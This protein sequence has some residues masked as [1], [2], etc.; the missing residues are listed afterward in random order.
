MELFIRDN[1]VISDSSLRT[2]N[3]NLD[4]VFMAGD[5]NSIFLNLMLDFLIRKLI[6]ILFS[7]FNGFPFEI[8]MRAI[9]V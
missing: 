1:Y 5:L 6:I 2:N 9:E 4:Q 8:S 3:D 7:E